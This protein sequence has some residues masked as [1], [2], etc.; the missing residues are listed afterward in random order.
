MIRIVSLGAA[1]F[2]VVV[3]GFFS[4]GLWSAGFSYGYWGPGSF[5]GIVM[6]ALSVGVGAIVFLLG[7]IAERDQK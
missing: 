6:F 2:V 4:L 3:G 7:R 1:L 5:L